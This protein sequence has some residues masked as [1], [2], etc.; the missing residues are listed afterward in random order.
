MMSDA[1]HILST[2]IFY[3]MTSVHVTGNVNE[4][5]LIWPSVQALIRSDVARPND[6]LS[7]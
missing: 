7:L 3:H 5:A 6:H 2:I 4:P 1:L